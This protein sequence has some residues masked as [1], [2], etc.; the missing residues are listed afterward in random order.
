M[1][2][3]YN[4]TIEAEIIVVAESQSEAEQAALHSFRDLDRAEFGASAGVLRFFPCDW[5]EDAIP[6]GYRDPDCSDRTVGEWIDMGAAPEYK[7]DS[8]ELKA[9]AKPKSSG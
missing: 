4:V 3:L 7:A 8:A 2:R 1:K 9:I 6:F 5:D